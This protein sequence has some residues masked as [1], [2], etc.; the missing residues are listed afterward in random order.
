MT[1]A[2]E[3]E[4]SNIL[5]VVFASCYHLFKMMLLWVSPHR[6]S[7]KIAWTRWKSNSNST[8]I[9]RFAITDVF[10]FWFSSCSKHLSQCLRSHWTRC[11]P[12][13]RNAAV[14]WKQVTEGC[15]LKSKSDDILPVQ[16]LHDCP[17]CSLLLDEWNGKE[18][19]IHLGIISVT[20]EKSASSLTL[21]EL[22]YTYPI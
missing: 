4:L 11:Q 1:T 10:I 19:I 17:D 9:N 12:Q 5:S 14:I 13:Q 21:V 8:I 7:W 3:A 15:R 16:Y 18:F 6:A 20:C 22:T 2:S